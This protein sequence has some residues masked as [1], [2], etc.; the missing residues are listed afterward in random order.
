MAAGADGV[1]VSEQKAC[2]DKVAKISKQRTTT[3]SL[4]VATPE[5]GFAQVVAATGVDL[6]ALAQACLKGYYGGK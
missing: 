5:G 6:S 1:C 4:L 2:R 3:D